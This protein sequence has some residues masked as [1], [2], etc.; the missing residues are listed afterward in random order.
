LAIKI[1][2]TNTQ[3]VYSGVTLTTSYVEQSSDKLVLL[4]RDAQFSSDLDNSIILVSDDVREYHGDEAWDMIKDYLDTKDP[5]GRTIVRNSITREGWLAQFNSF[6]ISTST[7]NG[8]YSKNKSGQDTGLT[9]YVMKDASGDT[10]AVEALCA[11]TIVTWEA[12]F[13]MDIVGGQLF[14]AGPPIDDVYMFVTAAPDIPAQYGGSVEFTLGGINLKD[15]GIGG[16]CDFDGR[17]AKYVAYDPV[18]HSGKFEFVLNHAA[19]VKHS[20][21]IVFEL[22]RA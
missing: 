21:T 14:Q 22:F 6:R 2:H 8:V 3:T 13:N 19:G 5:T 9:T 12:N 11:K 4:W 18:Y 10:T 1:K 15:I 7:T 20:F 17:A 16:V